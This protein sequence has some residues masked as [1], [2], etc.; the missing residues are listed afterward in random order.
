M[1]GLHQPVMLAEVVEALAPKDGAIYVDAT[2]G[3]GGY[4]K[5]VLNAADCKVIAIDRDPDAIAAGN[6][7]ADDYHGRLI[8]T[9][10]QFSQ[11]ATLASSL[12]AVFLD[13][14]M[15]D[16]GLSST[17]IHEA[18]R[19]FS[20]NLD[21]PLDMRMSKTGANA[22]AFVNSATEKE[23]VYVLKT[24]GEERAATKIAKAIIRTRKEN[25][26][27]R[28]SQLATIIR[29][30]LPKAK[31]GQIDPATRSFQA[32]RIHINNEIEEISLALEAS[33]KCLKPGGVLAVVSFHSLEDRVVKKFMRERSDQA[34]KPSRHAP[35]ASPTEPTF[36]L[37][38]K[39]PLYP[40]EDEVANN[41]SARSARLRVAHRTD[42]P[43]PFSATEAR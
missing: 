5:A 30:V 10:G 41:P 20:F 18:E 33:E 11:L 38:S 13:G 35:P 7:M 3:R 2:F 26:L 21:G 16:L 22:E 40:S 24:Y 43:H 23:L 32:I 1:Q 4:S 28:T 17:Q 9:S 19:G 15:F 6:L 29:S 12:G 14:V 27:T 37:I 8:L 31:P 42:A 25:P 34:P 36:R 39:R